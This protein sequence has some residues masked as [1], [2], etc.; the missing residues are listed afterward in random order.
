[1]KIA[2]VSSSMLTCPPQNYGGLEQVVFD[3]S[4]GLTKLNHKVVLFAPKGSQVPPNGFL[5]EC[6]EAKGTVNVD[7]LKAENDMW[8]KY[9]DK[10][11]DFDI[12]NSHD[13]FGFCYASKAKNLE[14]KMA[15]THHGGLNMDFW[16]KSK[17]PFNLNLIAISD[18]MVSVYASQGFTAKRAYNGV[19]LEKYPFKKE[20]GDRLM[21]LGR[22]SKIKAPHI[23]IEVARKLNMGLDIVGGTSFVDNP[24][25][26]DEVKRMCDGKQIKFIG[27]VNHETKLKYLQNAKALLV[28]SVFGEPFG[29]IS[30]ESMAVG[31]PVIALND[32][33]LSEIVKEGGIVCND[34]ESMISSLKYVDRIEPKM[35][36]ENAERF[37]KENAALR[38]LELYQAILEGKEW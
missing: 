10:L 30:V 11:D 8:E 38:Y 32:G 26:V 2:L 6:G 1:M 33:A 14:L 37:S 34:V 16:G 15:H 19:D 25:Y 20:K 35:C 18:W 22:I 27:E 24:N 23:A 3:L 21:F 13:W 12:I 17:P 7:W 4:C 5:V 29:L 28:P 31:T 36:R 9:K